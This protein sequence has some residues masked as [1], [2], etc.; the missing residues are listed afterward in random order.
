MAAILFFAKGFRRMLRSEQAYLWDPF[1]VTDVRG[2]TLAGIVG[3]GDIGKTIASRASCLGLRVIGCKQNINDVLGCDQIRQLYAPD[4]LGEM[5]RQCDYVV[6][7]TPLT[8]ATRG[9]IDEQ[10]LRTMKPTS[11][12]INIGRG[13]VVQEAALVRALLV[14][15]GLRARLWMSSTKNPSRPTALCL[16]WKTCSSH[17]TVQI[18]RRMFSG[19]RSA[20]SLQISCAMRMVSHCSTLS[21]KRPV[22]PWNHRQ[23][24]CPKRDEQSKLTFSAYSGVSNRTE[25]TFLDI[26]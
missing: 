23:F 5:L 11:V 7:C 12:I 8:P 14:R 17:P 10:A 21:T 24:F 22:S 18:S 1:K 2:Q 15:D 13:P 25:F 3:V 16:N 19:L 6:I 26:G 9:M 20:F 4:H